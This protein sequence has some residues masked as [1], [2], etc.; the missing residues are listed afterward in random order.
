MDVDVDDEEEGR[1]KMLTD[2]RNMEGGLKDVL[3]VLRMELELEMDGAE[4]TTSL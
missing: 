4:S 3:F 2:D 1:G